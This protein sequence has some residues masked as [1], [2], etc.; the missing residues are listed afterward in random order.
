MFVILVKYIKPLEQV[1]KYL[2]AHREFLKECYAR[3]EF[4][5]SGRQNPRI[6][7]I[8]LANVDDTAKV[9]ELIK[10]DPY[11]INGVA[12]YDVLEFDPSLYDERFECFIHKS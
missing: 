8:I 3:R 1:D 9:W 5:C 2:N 11:Y 7:G 12:D 4:I 10:Q 6:G